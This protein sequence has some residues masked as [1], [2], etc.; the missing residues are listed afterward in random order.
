[1][2]RLLIA[3]CPLLAAGCADDPKGLLV[4]INSVSLSVNRNA[5]DDLADLQLSV[6]LVARGRGA[7]AS[8]EE[9]TALTL[10][11]GD[12]EIAFA[13]QLLGTSGAGVLDDVTLGK[14]DTLGVRVLNGDVTNAQLADVC[15]RPMDL[16][17]VF[18]DD[19]GRPEDT[20]TVTV[21]CS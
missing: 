11:D 4:T 17:V 1:M 18:D 8:V 10:P 9:V 14:G 6:E 7:T 13:P 5:P 16:T 3:V 20:A 12:F 19:G 15:M 2:R 21:S